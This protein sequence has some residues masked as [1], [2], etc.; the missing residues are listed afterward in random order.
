MKIYNIAIIGFGFSGNLLLWHLINNAK[1]ECNIAIFDENGN[2]AG[3]GVAYSTIH[4]EHLLNVRANKMGAYPDGIDGFYLWLQANGYD[5][6]ADD[7]VPRKIYGKYLSEILAQSKEIAA[8]KNI[9]IDFYHEKLKQAIL[10]EDRY[11]LND[12]IMA[13]KLV[14]AI[15][16]NLSGMDR[17]WD[18]DFANLPDD[19]PAVIIGAGLTAVDAIISLLNI[20]WKNEIIVISRKGKFPLAHLLKQNHFAIDDPPI[21]LRLSSYLK[22]FRNIARNHHGEWPEMV[23]AIRPH[24]TKIWRNLLEWDKKRLIGKY[25]TW[26]NIHR[27]RMALSIW[28]QLEEAKKS[29]KLRIIKTGDHDIPAGHILRCTGPNYADCANFIDSLAENGIV[30]KSISGLKIQDGYRVSTSGLPAIYAIGTILLGEML[31]STAVPE[32]RAQA[33]LVADELSNRH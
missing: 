21:G 24:I 15:G 27:H 11:L 29:G 1:S 33:K 4:D 2:S 26:W 10:V 20:G 18:L 6:Q 32:L 16:N 14:L 9:S 5:Y 19:K 23:D 17:I 22:Y 12:K 13:E 28:H 31:E 8:K 3:L 25:F 30:K 7:F